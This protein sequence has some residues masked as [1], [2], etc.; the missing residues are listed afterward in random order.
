MSLA[1]PEDFRKKSSQAI[2]IVA[3]PLSFLVFMLIYRPFSIEEQL[4][5]GRFSFGVNL[6]L[7]SCIL[8]GTTALMRGLFYL[9][10]RRIDR[11]TYYFWCLL[12]ISVGALFVALYVWLMSRRVDPY[13]LVVARAY[14]WIFPVLIFP[15]VITAM[16][17]FLVERYRLPVQEPDEEQKLRFYDERKNLKL[18]V[19]AASVLYIAAKENYVQVVYL[20][21]ERVRDYLVRA[22]MRSI[23]ELC[24]RG[25][26]VRCHRSYYLNPHHVKTLRR[27][28]EGVIVA[29]LQTAGHEVP[30]TKRYYDALVERL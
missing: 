17:L 4:Q 18:V 15:Y 13:F 23:E 12:E 3:L 5:L 28:K 2:H 30:V 10:R 14:G 6:T 27:E 19:T 22:S 7:V 11:L 24:T 16:A 26:L 21:G 9:L 25:G 8:L 1:M 29:E 20:D